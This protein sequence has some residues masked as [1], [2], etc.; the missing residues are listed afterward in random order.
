MIVEWLVMQYEE[1]TQFFCL[2]LPSTGAKSAQLEL[3]LSAQF[4][5]K[6]RERDYIAPILRIGIPGNEAFLV[7]LAVP[8]IM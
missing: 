2:T 7:Y 1:S 3:N 6:P 5:E 8:D 4:C